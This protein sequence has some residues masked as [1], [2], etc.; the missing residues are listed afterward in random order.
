MYTSYIGKKFLDIYNK[1]EQK[2]LSAKEF[3]NSVFF[4]I[5]FN[6]EKYLMHVENYPFFQPLNKEE[7]KLVSETNSIAQIKLNK[8]HDKIVNDLPN[9]SIYVGYAASNIKSTTTGQI[10]VNY[11][12]TS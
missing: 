10:S 6:D 5:F 3:F 11:T 4:P 2:N 1:K 8:L 9:G 7:K 12:I